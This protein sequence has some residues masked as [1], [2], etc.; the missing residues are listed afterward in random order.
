MAAI[1]AIYGRQVATGLAS[2]ETVAPTVDE[3]LARRSAILGSGYPYLVAMREGQVAGYAYA[4]AYRT[5]AAYRMT[6]ENS[7][8]VAPAFQGR[9]IG[10]ALLGSLIA[11]CTER[12]Y[13]Q[14]VAVIGDSG[15]AASIALHRRMGF[16]H[17]GVLRRVGFKFDRWVD[18]VLMQRELAKGEKQ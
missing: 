2:F 14:I 18:T 4:S 9:G 3:M 6:A 8:Y 11:E 10:A 16:E 1:Q 12:G 17:V 5:R 13:R 15:N 7:V